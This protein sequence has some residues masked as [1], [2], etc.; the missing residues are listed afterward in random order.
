MALIQKCANKNANVS[1]ITNSISNLISQ[2]MCPFSCSL[3]G[4]LKFDVFSR[5][6][7]AKAVTTFAHCVKSETI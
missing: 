2:A 6:I 4:C 7:V 1:L 5:D 3:K